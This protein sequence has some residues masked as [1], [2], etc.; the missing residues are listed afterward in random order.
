MLCISMDY[1]I[2]IACT[3][4][5]DDMMLL[6]FEK[7]IW[8]QL[9]GKN[10]ITIGSNVVATLGVQRSCIDLVACT[11]IEIRTNNH[12]CFQNY[13]FRTR[14]NSMEVRY[15][16]ISRRVVYKSVDKP[17]KNIQWF[18]RLFCDLRTPCEVSMTVH[19]SL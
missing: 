15:R 17:H 16:G 2:A 11:I 4:H 6:F 8:A 5:Q 12:T 9:S 3:I 7:L 1:C 10:N 19:C 13:I 18:F 14:L